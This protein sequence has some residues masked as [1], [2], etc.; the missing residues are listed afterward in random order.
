MNDEKGDPASDPKIAIHTS[1]K[2]KRKVTD[3]SNIDLQQ[4]ILSNPTL[5][6]ITMTIDP[7]IYDRSATC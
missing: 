4:K 6:I 5:L 2:R 7:R 1:D 3:T